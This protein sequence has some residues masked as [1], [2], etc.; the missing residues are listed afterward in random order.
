MKI[1]INL[2]TVA[3]F[4][5]HAF[6]TFDVS[7]MQTKVCC[8]VPQGSV[9]GPILFTLH[10]LPLGNIIQRHSIHFHYHSFLRGGHP[11]GHWKAARDNLYCNRRYTNNA[12]LNWIELHHHHWL[13]RPHLHD[14]FPQYIL[15][16]VRVCCRLSADAV[17]VLC[18][19]LI[20]LSIDL[21]SPH[22]K[23]KMSKREFIRNTRRAAH[24]VS[25]DFVGHLYDNIYL[26]GHVAA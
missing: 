16:L 17:Y 21:T 12:E 10:M 8:G 13:H 6:H 19:S 24:N 11:L 23:N 1:K 5:P 9:L 20:L 15:S 22:V 3:F 7:S 14:L 25:D 4:V 18:Y 26:I 2:K